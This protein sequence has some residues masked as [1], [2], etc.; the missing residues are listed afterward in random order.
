MDLAEGLLNM[1][2]L[3]PSIH[4]LTSNHSI[5]RSRAAEVVAAAA[6][7]LD[8]LKEEAHRGGA[9][10]KLIAVYADRNECHEARTKSLHAI[11][12]L[13]KGNST[14]QLHFLYNQVS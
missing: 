8:K 5:I 6:Q 7:N 13:I 9:L 11:S 12:A 4:C 1:G 14:A 3:Q 10:E 2:G